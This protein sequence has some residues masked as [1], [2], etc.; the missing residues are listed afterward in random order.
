[1]YYPRLK[2]MRNFDMFK[3]NTASEVPEQSQV[4]RP[5]LL[6]D[7]Y[8]YNLSDAEMDAEEVDYW[9]GRLEESLKRQISRS[10]A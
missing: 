1:M 10:P 2:E 6:G 3:K 4:L 5:E 8:N 7:W 9:L